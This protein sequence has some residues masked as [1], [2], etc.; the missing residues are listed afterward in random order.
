MIEALRREKLMS[1]ALFAS[2]VLAGLW[3]RFA[4]LS[5]KPFHHDEGVNSYFLLALAK[6]GS[7]AYRY[8]PEN[9][10]GPTLYYFALTALR[11][12]GET[13]FALRFWPCLFGLLTILLLWVWR[14][15][16]GSVGLPV[17]A[18]LLALSP[19][20]VF[21]SR[22][23]IHEMMFGWCSLA[24]AVGAWRYAETKDFKWMALLSIGA[25]VLFATKE[26][27]MI[28]AVV[29][30]VA[31]ISASIWDVTR[32][33]LRENR[34]TPAAL[35]KQLRRDWAAV[36]PSLDH[37]LSALIIFI[38]INV[39]FYSSAFTNWGGV[40]DAFKS[41]M[42]WTKERANNDHVH[43]K[44][45]YLGIL[46]KLELPLL[47]GGLLAGALIVWRG[48][49][50]WLFVGAWTFGLTLGYSLIPYKT[51]WLM[52]SFMIPLAL[53]GGYAAEQLF[54]LLQ[55]L[56]WRIGCGAVILA[57]LF[58]SYRLAYEVNFEKYEDNSNSAGYF[59]ALGNR[60]GLTPYL[61]GQYGYVYAQT[62][63]DFFEFVNTVK[64]AADQFPT[65]KDTGIFIGS[66]DYWPLPWYLRDY[67][68][69]AYTGTLPDTVDETKVAQPIIVAR[70]DQQ[71][72]MLDAPGWHQLGREFT[73]RPGVQLLV[74]VRDKQQP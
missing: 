14:D 37:T 6:Q 3:F 17:A 52:V 31:L 35:V 21:F 33:L 51:P 42:H 34:F 47:L 19:G 69:V 22:Y 11:T 40:A 73:L 38:F 68:G 29:L 1:T 23:F 13:D 32:Q 27:A 44:L 15:K 61:D 12:F 9:Y 20:L 53:V 2:A 26:T 45:Y 46:F 24:V 65:Q 25:G 36:R 41:I 39:F 49:R 30:V 72:K 16:L 63:R 62:D 4:Q 58:F 50:F 67:T 8:N 48:T 64:Q 7:S 55:P 59:T 71:G 28:T 56:A 5:L 74:Y 10:H 60:F 57:A 18:L 70:A 54:Y 66:P 43:S